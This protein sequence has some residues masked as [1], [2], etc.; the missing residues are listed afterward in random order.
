MLNSSF[1]PISNTGYFF[2]FFVSTLIWL[3]YKFDR[4]SNSKMN[5]MTFNFKPSA[6]HR[7][8]TMTL[9]PAK[10]PGTHAFLPTKLPSKMG[11]KILSSDL[12]PHTPDR[13]IPS[14][15]RCAKIEDQ[16]LLIANLAKKMVFQLVS[17]NKHRFSLRSHPFE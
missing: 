8:S 10:H 13:F 7:S 5:Y 15:A 3:I 12:N 14:R 4:N 2:P 1:D 16:R 9:S 6:S 17:A 11:F